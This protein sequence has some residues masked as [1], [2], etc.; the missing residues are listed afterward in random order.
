MKL[1]MSGGTWLREEQ[2]SG[3]SSLSLGR[4][5]PKLAASDAE[6]STLMKVEGLEVRYG[7]ADDAVVAV[8]D[9]NF[10]LHQREVI[11]VAGES[12]SG[13]S[14][15]AFALAHLL[16]GEGGIS[17]GRVLWY[18]LGGDPIDL[19]QATAEQ[20]RRV[21][22]A[23]ISIVLQSAMN[24]M[25]PVLTLQDQ[26]QDVI[27]AHEP[28]VGRRQRAARIGQLLEMVGIPRARAGAYPHELSGGMRQRAMI[29]LAL[30]L[31]PQL[32]ILD[33]PT[34]ALDVVM[35]RQIL[36]RLN[37][38]RQ[39]LGF[40]VLFITHD[41]SLL[42]EMADRVLVMYAGSVVETADA[43]DLYRD[44][45]HPYSEGLL[46]SFPQVHGERRDL[47][48]IPGSPPNL[49]DLPTGCT[50]HPRCPY[51]MEKCSIFVPRFVPRARADGGEAR[52]VACHLFTEV[53]DVAAPFVAPTGNAR[54]EQ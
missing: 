12:G 49:R 11:G 7:R 27:K 50:F 16:R 33:E 43:G 5:M 19:A 46:R 47:T 38:L 1:A 17:A 14:T 42:L 13:K 48:G 53:G 51:A 18:G 45:M 20:L 10:A 21:R 32:V 8:R 37:E 30:A 28:E 3:S 31:S 26:I 54:R 22:W 9:A 23:G 34:T 40:A 44:P 4:R 41:L 35:Q 25:N 36:D 39:E 2:A 29:A 52:Q 24:A 6:P 15:L